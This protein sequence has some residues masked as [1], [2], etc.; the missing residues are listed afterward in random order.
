VLPDT[1]LIKIHKGPYDKK[2]ETTGMRPQLK[3]I[4]FPGNFLPQ[5]RAGRAVV[6]GKR[7]PWLRFKDAFKAWLGTTLNH[8]GVPGGVRDVQ[9]EDQVTG[10]RVQIRVGVLFTR[11]S[12]DGR[13]YYFRRVSGK[14]DGSG[15][16]CG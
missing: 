8:F 1:P 13:D 11:I 14:Y 6:S 12:I 9:F 15:M 3:L 7:S 10:Q 2:K 16:G 5:E 4:Q